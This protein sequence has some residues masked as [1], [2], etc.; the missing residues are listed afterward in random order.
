[1]KTLKNKAF[2][3]VPDV[4]G[5]F[6]FMLN[7]SNPFMKINQTDAKIISLELL[8]GNKYNYSNN[9]RLSNSYNG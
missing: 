6:Q 7:I 9:C 8:G 5:R 3:I 1:L 4:I 2:I